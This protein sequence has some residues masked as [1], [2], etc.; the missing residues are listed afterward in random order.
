MSERDEKT[1]RD[2]MHHLGAVLSYFAE[3]HESDRCK[4]FDDALA[5][6]NRENPDARVE[7]ESGYCLMLV[8]NGPLDGMLDI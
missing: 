7:P 8:R 4:A 1:N 2:A 3:L 5:F 6:Y